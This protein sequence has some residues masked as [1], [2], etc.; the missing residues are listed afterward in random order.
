MRCERALPMLA[1]TAVL[2]GLFVLAAT[3]PAGAT[4]PPV[5]CSDGNGGIR[6]TVGNLTVADVS[7]AD[8]SADDYPVLQALVR[9]TQLEVRA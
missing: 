1:F 8:V 5:S 6:D 4:A 2:G 3:F 9:A 7:D